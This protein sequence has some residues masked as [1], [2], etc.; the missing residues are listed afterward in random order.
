MTKVRVFKFRSD[1]LMRF[2]WVVYKRG[3]D[4]E[5]IRGIFP[6]E[7]DPTFFKEGKNEQLQEW[8]W[9]LESLPTRDDGT[10]CY[11]DFEQ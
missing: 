1:D 9:D 7:P 8:L 11:R 4:F 6:A 3:R 5:E 2:L 10:L